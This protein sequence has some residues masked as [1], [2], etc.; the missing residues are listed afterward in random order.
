MTDLERYSTFVEWVRV[1][2]RKGIQVG[3]R[4]AGG[5]VQ[6]EQSDLRELMV[7]KAPGKAN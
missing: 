3:E 2:R 7:Q 6:Q 4:R 5:Q 1:R